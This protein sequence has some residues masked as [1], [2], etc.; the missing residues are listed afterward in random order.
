M[1]QLIKNWIRVEERKKKEDYK[2][3]KGREKEAWPTPNH[4]QAMHTNYLCLQ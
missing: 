4:V 2:S 3:T 1:Q